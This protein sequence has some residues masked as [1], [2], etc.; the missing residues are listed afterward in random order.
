M[1]NMLTEE[2]GWAHYAKDKG[3]VVTTDASNTGLGITL[4]QKHL[5]GE[6]KP[7]VNESRYSNDWAT[8]FNGKTGLQRQLS[9][10]LTSFV[11]FSN[12]K[13]VFHKPT[14]KLYQH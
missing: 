2:L 6:L 11:F 12:E 13:K 14:T 8:L 9:G 5:D 10:D 1:K 7:L 3:N 4:W